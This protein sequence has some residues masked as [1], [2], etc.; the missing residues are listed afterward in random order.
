[1]DDTNP[2]NASPQSFD[3]NAQKPEATLEETPLNTGNG[4]APAAPVTPVAPVEPVT[5]IEP[6]APAPSEPMQIPIIPATPEPTP[7][8]T[9]IDATTPEINDYAM[10]NNTKKYLIIGGAAIGVL[11]IGYICYALFFSGSTDVAAELPPAN[12]LSG[13]IENKDTSKELE[14]VVNNLKDVYSEET[15]TE[16]TTIEITPTEAEITTESDTTTKVER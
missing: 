1:M 15:T 13:S 10:A 5:P 16:E 8:T 4:V 2:N 12:T 6:A 7:E 3:I 11:T 14:S 9:N